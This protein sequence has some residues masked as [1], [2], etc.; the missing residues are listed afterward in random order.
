[1]PLGRPPGA[2]YVRCVS[3]RLQVYAALALAALAATVALAR[4]PAAAAASCAS[5]SALPGE[6]SRSQLGRAIVCVSNLERRAHGL[7]ALSLNRQLSNA[8]RRHS[9][10]MVRRGYFAHTGPSGDTFVERIRNAGYLRSARTWL[11]GENL[12]WGWGAAASP[13]R[14]VRAWMHSPE[15]R[16]ILLRPS[17]GEIG[18]GVVRGGPH[19]KAAPEATFTA[20]FGVTD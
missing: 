5:A 3:H 15:H 4:P 13:S 18:V 20:D 8:A 12:A 7:R 10:D 2:P 11:V 6:A 9:L 19:P 1:M 14:I 16:K 17:Y